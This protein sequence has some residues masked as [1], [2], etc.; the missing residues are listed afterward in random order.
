MKYCLL[1][2]LLSGCMTVPVTRTMPNLPPSLQQPPKELDQIPRNTTKLSDVLKSVTTN[3]S[4][5]HE[6]AIKLEL[7][8][9]WY[10]QQK[11]IFDSVK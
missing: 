3:Y 10:N 8:Q 6:C 9:S 1:A 4:Y 2:L 11:E 7:I 5:C